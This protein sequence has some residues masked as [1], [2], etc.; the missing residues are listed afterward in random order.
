MHDDAKVNFCT[1]DPWLTKDE[2]LSTTQA[3]VEDD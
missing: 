3:E 2:A 1:S